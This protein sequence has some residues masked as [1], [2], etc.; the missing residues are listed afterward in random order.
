MIKKLSLSTA[1]AVATVG[2]GAFT[3]AAEAASI[4]T[5]FNGNSAGGVDGFTDG[6]NMFDITAWGDS[7][8]ILVGSNTC[9][10]KL[11]Q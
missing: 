1:L 10:D 7:T 5:L 6:G 8:S 3:Q 9:Q 2:I 4:T 11:S